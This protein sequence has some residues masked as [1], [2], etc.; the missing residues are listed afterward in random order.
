MYKTLPE[1]LKEAMAG[2]PKITG[3]ALAKACGVA[4]ASVS[5]WLSGKSKTMEG[6]NL[7]AACEF[8]KIRPKWL[9]SGTGPMRNEQGHAWQH[10]AQEPVADYLPE[11][12]ADP[13][14]AEL[15]DLIS[16]MDGPSKMESL[17]Q[18]RDCKRPISNRAQVLADMFDEL[19]DGILKTRVYARIT[20]MVGDAMDGI[21]PEPRATPAPAAD[22]KKQPV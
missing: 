15:L 7:V 17:L 9:A 18:L 4:P 22:Q 11:K 12:S 19:P 3:R 8:L 16:R 20:A 21:E 10:A 1:R 2:P 13:I 6:A 5:D 14:T